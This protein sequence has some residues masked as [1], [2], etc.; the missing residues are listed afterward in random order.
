M[1]KLPDWGEPELGES[2]SSFRR[3][4]RGAGWPESQCDPIR[5]IG[6]SHGWQSRTA[7]EKSANRFLTYGTCPTAIE[8]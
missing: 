3:I 2:K 5:A 4:R 6:A 7:D 8:S 1:K